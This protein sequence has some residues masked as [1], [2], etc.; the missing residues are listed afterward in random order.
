MIVYQLNTARIHLSNRGH[1][2]RQSGYPFGVEGKRGNNKN[3]IV[4]PQT[5]QTHDYLPY[6]K[7]LTEPVQRIL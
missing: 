1:T 7:G 2:E 3:I 6:G 5:R 4:I